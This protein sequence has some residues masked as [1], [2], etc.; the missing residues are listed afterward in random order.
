MRSDLKQYHRLQKWYNSD[1]LRFT[2]NDINLVKLSNISTLHS[3]AIVKVKSF[4]RNQFLIVIQIQYSFLSPRK[5]YVFCI[6]LRVLQS[7]YEIHAIY[8]ANLIKTYLCLK[9]DPLPKLDVALL[10]ES[11]S[12][13]TELNC[14]SLTTFWFLR[15]SVRPTM[16]YPKF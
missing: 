4:L 16:N 6:L 13:Q 3:K 5:N 7:V 8:V 12:R 2:K 1:F 11:D 14:L 15:L 10:V 9:K